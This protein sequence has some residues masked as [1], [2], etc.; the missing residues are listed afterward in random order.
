MEHLTRFG[1]KAFMIMPLPRTRI[2]LSLPDTSSITRFKPNWLK[3]PVIIR[4]YGLTKPSC[5][6]AFRRDLRRDIGII[7]A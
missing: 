7:R 5:R 2:F 6:S 4:T 3:I 1:K